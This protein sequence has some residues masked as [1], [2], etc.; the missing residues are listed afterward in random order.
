MSIVTSVASYRRFGTTTVSSNGFGTFVTPNGEC[1][2]SYIADVATAREPRPFQR[3]DILWTFFQ[4]PE[5]I[6]ECWWTQIRLALYHWLANRPAPPAFICSLR[7]Q[8]L[9][10]WGALAL[11]T[12]LTRNEEV[13]WTQ[14]WEIFVQTFHSYRLFIH[15]D[16]CLERH[17]FSKLLFL[18][19]S[20]QNTFKTFSFAQGIYRCN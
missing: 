19:D 7:A 11:L 8:G 4:R 2:N 3:P 9:Q 18:S 5:S 1:F 20:N 16:W 14:T 13:D 12:F 10:T 17:L 15:T 6:F